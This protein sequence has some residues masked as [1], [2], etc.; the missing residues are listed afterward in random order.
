MV[1]FTV[2][3]WKKNMG[4]ERKEREGN[5]SGVW[6]GGREG[7]KEK[8]KE[9]RKQYLESEKEKQNI[10]VKKKRFKKQSAT[11]FK[12]RNLRRHTR[13]FKLE[14]TFGQ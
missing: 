2:R 1:R 11:K 7:R 6:R 9:K 12:L 3:E 10:R 5:R 4:P 13:M 14:A 8:K